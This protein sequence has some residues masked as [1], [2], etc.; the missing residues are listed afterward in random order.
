MT[1][2]IGIPAEIFA[3]LLL[4]LAALL[5][6]AMENIAA[7]TPIYDALLTLKTTVAVGDAQISKPLLLW[8]NDGL[9]AIFFLLVA[10]EIKREVRDGA[11]SSW[12]D[13]S[14]PVYGAIGGIVVPSLVFL[15][16]V[17]VDA[18]AARGW[19][20]PAATDI[21]FAL[22]VLSLF[23]SRV[24]PLLKTFLLAL[25]VVDDLAA[26]VIIAAFYTAD[27]SLT[28]LCVAGLCLVILFV[29]N[30]AGNRMGPAYVL[31]GLILWVAVLKSGVHATLAGVALGFAIPLAPDQ[32]GRS[33][34][35]RY[36][37]A[38]HPWVSFLVLPVFAFAN[39]GV[40]L[41]GL[42]LADVLNPLSLGIAAGLFLGKQIGV[43]G[44]VFLVVSL[45]LARRPPELSWLKLYA[46]SCL[47]G[48]GFTMSLFVGGLAFD[49]IAEQNMVRLGVIVGSVLSGSLG[50]ILLLLTPRTASPAPPLPQDR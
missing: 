15:A 45:G 26:I 21:A 1:R 24:P 32:Y 49:Q 13:A 16:I 41:A 46:A 22:G 31:I 4:A 11:L 18:P 43:F 23:G 17:R 8:I 34:A 35:R 20:I 25:A 6:V 48:I 37:H 27:L 9:M 47:A 7:L 28:A 5:G 38:L 36:E 39:A 29:L 30:R 2:I 40:P 12:A 3:G 50:A 19:A 10:L 14:L 44:V 42:A 33:M